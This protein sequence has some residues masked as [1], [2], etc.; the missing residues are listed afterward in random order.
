MQKIVKFIAAIVLSF[1]AGA[2][3]SLATVPNI[4]TWYAAIDKPPLLPP[5]YVFGPVW[6]MLYIAIGVA[7]YLV[8][9]SRSKRSKK[10]AYIAFAVQLVL[11]T[12]WS[13]VFFGLHMPWGGVIIILLLLT[14]IAW[15]MYEFWRHSR[16]A[17][18]LL[19]PYILWVSFATYLT[20]GVAIVN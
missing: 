19:V 15:T 14:A 1:T 16:W 10:Y 2:I 12:L 13:L 8:W 3:G 6:T 7:L 11:N 17:A 4:P 20:V 5:N 18:Y 9:I